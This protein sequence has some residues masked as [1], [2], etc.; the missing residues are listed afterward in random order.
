MR[1]APPLP[2]NESI[3]I[4]T[5]DNKYVRVD[6]STDPA[7]PQPG[8]GTTPPEQYCAYDPDNLS[9][10]TPVMPGKTTIF[11]SKQTGMYCRL[12]P[13]PSAPSL[14]G[15][16]C[17]QPTPVT[18]TIVT[19]TGDGLSK[20]GVPLTPSGPGGAL[21]LDPTPGPGQ[22][23][24]TFPKPA[25]SPPPPPPQGE[26]LSPTRQGS[27]GPNHQAARRTESAPPMWPRPP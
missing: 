12:I 6:N 14:T 21:V 15:M 9:S 26:Q 10:T 5:P 1:A 2:V 27:P 4:R 18:A 7:R 22:D 19:Y 23:K 11:K 3:N 17:D 13:L 24:L 20:D 16:I 25:P 8:T